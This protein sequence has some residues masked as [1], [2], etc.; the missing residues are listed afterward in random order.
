MVEQVAHNDKV[1]GSVPTGPTVNNLNRI[2]SMLVRESVILLS[3]YRKILVILLEVQK[4]A[5]KD[6]NALSESETLLI[7]YLATFGFE[8]ISEINAAL[9]ACSNTDSGMI[10]L[11]ELSDEVRT[12]QSAN[13]K[14]RINLN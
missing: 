10:L 12:K 13:T 4:L 7:A 11:K 3:V 5:P 14:K 9:S 2:K 1:V 6:Y 8:R